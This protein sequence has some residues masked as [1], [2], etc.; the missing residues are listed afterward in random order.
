MTFVET[1]LLLALA[2]T[3]W[4]IWIH[5]RNLSRMLNWISGPLDAP[6]PHAEGIWG[7]FVSRMNQRVRTRQQEK[8]QL[9]VV[10]EQF[11]S[12]L[13]ALPD[14]VVF[15]NGERQILW[16]NS[17]AVS[18]LN[19]RP[20][21]DTGTPIE[22]LIR[23]PEFVSYIQGHN[24]EEALIY[25]PGR[26]SNACY[27]ITLISYGDDRLLLTARD[28]T[29]LEKL[30]NVRRDFV[31]N[32]SHELKTPLTVI[33]GFLETLQEHHSTLDAEKRHRYITLALQQS[34]QMNRLVQ[35]LLTLSSLESRVDF[36]DEQNVP[37]YPLLNELVDS[38]ESISA[39]SHEITIDCPKNLVIRGSSGSLR[40]VFGNLISNAVHYTPT[41]GKI[42][43]AWHEG[44]HESCITV[45]D[46]GIGIPA[47][48]LP[49][50][51]ER[52]YRVDH[53]R[54][55]E[56]GGT[57]LGLAIVKHALERHQGRLD[58]ESKE[59]EGSTFFAYLPNGRIMHP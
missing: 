58:V 22:Q 46:T 51:S 7:E 19:L 38:A 11:Q 14:G 15:M 56:N 1:L 12:A 57:G 9:E 54:S 37:L 27:M 5:R 17:L 43:I 49:R 23:D 33:S 39:K 6:V 52:F 24:F 35:D 59:G 25:H 36:S 28:L 32:V 42:H 47:V 41:H 45:S 10:L 2:V 18:M 8:N 48:H 16:M 13:E 29:R 50:I 20:G 3:G 30:E 34:E 31:A 53:G 21:Q 40:S 44:S 55:R 4:R 26:K